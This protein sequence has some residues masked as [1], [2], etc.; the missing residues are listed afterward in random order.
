[1]ARL[2]V[3]LIIGAQKA[4][5]TTLYRDLYSHPQVF[6]PAVKEPNALCTEDVLTESGR[7]AYLRLFSRARPDQ[8]WG[9]ASTHYSMLPDFRGV[10][11]RAKL[12]WG[13]DLKI[14]YLVRD[15]VAR[16]VSQH[17]HESGLRLL[18]GDINELIRTDSRFINYSNYPMQLRAWLDWFPREQIKVLRFED[19]VRDRLRTVADVCQFL[20]L[21]PHGLKVDGTQVH[22]RS[23]G[24]PVIVGVWRTLLGNGL[25]QNWLKPQLPLRLRDTLRWALLPRS[26]A[27]RQELTEQSTLYV[28][29]KLGRPSYS[30]LTCWPV[31]HR[32][33]SERYKRDGQ[34]Q[35]G[36]WQREANASKEGVMKREPRG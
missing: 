14:V 25:Y 20:D 9:E 32:Q 31:H 7:R 10:P 13:E 35:N 33:T 2:R 5:T 18:N 6:L 4:G 27:W 28:Y 12:V 26:T 3:F 22:N 8:V 16:I 1:M 29:D 17:H 21:E 15:P 24:K 19:F 30:E 23:A 36:S 11:R 34:D